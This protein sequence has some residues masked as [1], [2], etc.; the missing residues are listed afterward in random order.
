MRACMHAHK[1]LIRQ[2][3]RQAGRQAEKQAGREAGRQGGRQAGRQA[4]SLPSIQHA[5]LLSGMCRAQGNRELAIKAYA[6]A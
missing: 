2:A 4:G 5:H 1:Y 6:Y 3:G